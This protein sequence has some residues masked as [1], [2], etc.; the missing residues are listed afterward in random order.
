VGDLEVAIW[1]EAS[2]TVVLQGIVGST[3]YGLARKG[4]DVDR[5][6]VFYA[7]S[8]SFFGLHPPVGKAAT[9]VQHQ[10]SDLTLHEVGKFCALGLQCN[11]TI[12]ELLWLPDELY[13]IR[14]EEGHALISL[15]SAML[16]RKRVHD[17]FFGYA[18]QQFERLSNKA[19]FPD[20]PVNR[21]EKHARHL[22]RLLVQGYA[23]YAT[24]SMSVIV[25]N[26]GSY[27]DFG[28]RVAAGDLDL[29]RHLMDGFQEMFDRAASPLPEFPDSAAI[30]DFLRRTR[31]ALL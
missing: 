21:I 27:F 31:E 4:S 12:L 3:A 16:S 24:G 8:A 14:G 29:A 6:G 7:P 13:E 5:L 18:N 17:A 1:T 30:E 19:R 23:L 10:P 26:P 9:I 20:V 2:M 15:R 25:D 22:R 11:P 28:E